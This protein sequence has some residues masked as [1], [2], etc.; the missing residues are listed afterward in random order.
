MSNPSPVVP[1]YSVVT[2]CPIDASGART[3][4]RVAISL[5]EYI[6]KAGLDADIN[7]ASVTWVDYAKLV[8]TSTPPR[9]LSELWVLEFWDGADPIGAGETGPE[10]ELAAATAIWPIYI[11]DVVGGDVAQEHTPV[12]VEGQPGQWRTVLWRLHLADFRWGLREPFG[13]VLRLGTVN[14]KPV[15]VDT[16]MDKRGR[17]IVPTATLI[18]MALQAMGFTPDS[19]LI[20]NFDASTLPI[21]E[22]VNAKGVHAPTLLKDILDGLD[23]VACPTLDGGLRLIAGA[24]GA[25]QDVAWDWSDQQ[26]ARP[27]V[28]PLVVV[29][30]YP[31]PMLTTDVIAGIGVNMP[32]QYVFFDLEQNQWMRYQDA[33][34]WDTAY[35]SI[36]NAEAD[37]YNLVA[38][39]YSNYI[40]GQLGACVRLDPVV[41]GPAPILRRLVQGN[42]TSEILV[43]ARIMTP[44]W[45]DVTDTFHWVQATDFYSVPVDKIVNG[46]VIECTYKLLKL[47]TG[48]ADTTQP[49]KNCQELLGTGD[50][51]V[52]CTREYWTQVDGVWN[53]RYFEVG[54]RLG[55]TGEAEKLNTDDMAAAI[56]DPRTM[57]VRRPELLM[58]MEYGVEES[59]LRDQLEAKALPIAQR[60]LGVGTTMAGR[61]TYKKG[62]A[63]VGPDGWFSEVRWSQD[64]RLTI[65]K[66][67]GW[68]KPTE[69]GRRRKNTRS[70]YAGNEFQMG[71]TGSGGVTVA[72]N[73]NAGADGAVQPVVSGPGP[74][75]KDWGVGGSAAADGAFLV[76]LAQDGGGNGGDTNGTAANWT[77]IMND[78]ETG[79]TLKKNA[80]GDSATR[81]SPLKPRNPWYATEATFGWAIRKT[82]GDL[83]L[84]EAFETFDWSACK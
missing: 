28:D 53:P 84:V 3:G 52:T 12:S 47:S 56:A 19:P 7:T 22:D 67:Q 21:L 83:V 64:R 40:F 14:A 18:T 50:F 63:A 39:Q 73:V 41:Y 45:N 57:V 81:M 35:P 8:D 55:A 17:A 33:P 37:G 23:I 66:W 32:W 38:G 36:G 71:Y 62:F 69:Y 15:N 61:T 2:I 80:A 26:R 11:V 51:R 34:T 29:T 4:T 78:C 5:P 1:V 6:M 65:V 74:S 76:A 49:H 60:W 24:S 77:Y 42:V 54:Y 16:G 72:A 58:R 27:A 46:E 10:S 9:L 30:S 59:G 31:Q 75:R 44:Q 82:N 13:G 70:P 20:E 68:G 43:E 25:A 79:A 48:M